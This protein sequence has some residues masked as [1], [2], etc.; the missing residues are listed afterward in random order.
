VRRRDRML[1]NT[2]ERGYGARARDDDQRDP[3]KLARW[4]PMRRGSRTRQHRGHGTRRSPRSSSPRGGVKSYER[5]DRPAASMRPSAPT[6]RPTTASRTSRA[7]AA[8][9]AMPTTAAAS[10]SSRIRSS[11]RSGSGPRTRWWRSR[12]GSAPIPARTTRRREV[13]VALR[14]GDEPFQIIKVKLAERPQHFAA[15]ALVVSLSARPNIG[16]RPSC[17][18]I[19]HVRRLVPASDSRT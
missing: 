4:R 7:R 8:T 3:D 11:T 5:R 17:R 19:H 12:S 18:T 2:A 9:A 10:S 16:S 6:T 14:A 1:L 13:P 15:A